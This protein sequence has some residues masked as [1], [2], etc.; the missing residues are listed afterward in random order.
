VSEIIYRI[1]HH[2]RG[3]ACD[4]EMMEAGAQPRVVE[5]FNTEAEAWE[6]ISERE[7]LQKTAARRAQR[8]QDGP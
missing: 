8:R 1:L 6:W 3:T 5:T 2:K 7:H 4:V